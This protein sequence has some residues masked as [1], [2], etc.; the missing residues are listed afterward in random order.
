MRATQG[1]SAALA[2]SLAA[3]GW[4]AW[5][6]ARLRTALDVARQTITERAVADRTAA[7]DH[8]RTGREPERERSRGSLGAL[9]A[10]G[11]ALSRAEATAAPGP[12]AAPDDPQ[13]RRERR[14]NKLREVFGRR[15]G[16]SDD[17]YKARVGPVVAAALIAP[18]SRAEDSYKEAL[19]AAEV[20]AEQQAALDK[21]LAD[22]RAEIA[23][24][25]NQAI[26]AGDLTPYRR[27]SRG[28]LTFVGGTV[29]IMDGLDARMRETLSADQVTALG[30]SGFD[31]IEYVGLTVPWE[32]LNPPPPER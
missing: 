24:A 30:D 25:A 5:D 18:R 8:E 31:L 13:S 1:L 7:E 32:T 22:T 10:L 4:L 3:A 27:N 15:D 17:Q 23:A 20:T 21:A 16:E 2:V 9:G 11:R 14:Q 6:R 26:A 12:D 28:I 19:A 29:A